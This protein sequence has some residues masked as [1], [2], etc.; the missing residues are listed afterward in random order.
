MKRKGTDMKRMVWVRWMGSLVVSILMG[1]IA[2]TASAGDLRRIVV[3]QE[4]ILADDQPQ[5]VALTHQ[6]AAYCISLP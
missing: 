3:F 2:V 6:G 5:I 1:G 4:W